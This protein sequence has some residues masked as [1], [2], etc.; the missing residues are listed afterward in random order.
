MGWANIPSFVKDDGLGHWLP[1]DATYTTVLR[2]IGNP[3]PMYAKNVNID[4]PAVGVPCGYDLE[5]GG[6]VGP[7]GKGRKADF[8]FT[9]QRQYQDYFHFNVTVTLT[10]SNPGDGIQVTELP[11]DFA[12][13]Q[14]KWPRMAPSTG[15]QSNFSVN[16]SENQQGHDTNFQGNVA[17]DQVYFFRVRTVEQN[18]NMASALYGKIASGL[19]IT[20]QHAKNCYVSL[21]YYLNPTSND[22]NMEYGSTLFKNLPDLEVPRAP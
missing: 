1:W 8:I 17:S 21:N 18:G 3:I 9:L 13:S 10:F 16:F 6:W 20:P 2:K 5:I 7:Y 4:I 19:Q 15:Y 22:Q 14:F 11:K 12:N